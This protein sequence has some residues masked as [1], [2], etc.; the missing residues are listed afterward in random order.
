MSL[1]VLH[2]FTFRKRLRNMQREGALTG[3][4][5]ATLSRGHAFAF[6][7]V[8]ARYLIWQVLVCR[9]RLEKVLQQ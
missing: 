4:G 6:V 5:G 3:G 1:E 9:L 8:V 2:R 7:E